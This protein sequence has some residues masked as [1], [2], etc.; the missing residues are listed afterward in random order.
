MSIQTKCKRC[1]K[2]LSF[3][4]VT[5]NIFECADCR[6]RLKNNYGFLGNEAM[7]S[8]YLN[9]KGKFTLQIEQGDS[10]K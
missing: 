7:E 3:Y 1:A 8:A 4:E 6:T 5:N 10:V 9:T 2:D